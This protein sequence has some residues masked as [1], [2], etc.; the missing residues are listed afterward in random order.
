M[1]DQIKTHFQIQ[2][3]LIESSGG[4]FEVKLDG[5]KIFSKMRTGRFPLEN[6]IVDL[7]RNRQN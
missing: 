7:I 4:V 3:R 1:V 6:E 5:K 2:E